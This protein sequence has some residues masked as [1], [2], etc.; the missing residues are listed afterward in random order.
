LEEIEKYHILKT[1]KLN[2]WNRENTARDLGISQK[3][4][5]TKIKKYSL[6]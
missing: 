2:E 6:K 5:Y 3:T 4:L 1:L